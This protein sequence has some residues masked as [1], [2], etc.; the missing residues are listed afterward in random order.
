MFILLPIKDNNNHLII[1]YNYTLQENYRILLYSGF[2]R[3][4]LP[5]KQSAIRDFF[6]KNPRK[7]LGSQRVLTPSKSDKREGNKGR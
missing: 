2:P 5:A 1:I 7:S 4:I 3:P 6:M